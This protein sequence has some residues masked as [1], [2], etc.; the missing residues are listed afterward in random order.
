MRKQKG[1]TALDLARIAR[2]RDTIT[3]LKDA[4]EVNRLALRAAIMHGEQ[5]KAKALLMKGL[6]CSVFITL[7]VSS[8][9]RSQDR[10]TL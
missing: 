4:D 1:K 10:R 9:A 3:L 8:N 2:K 7:L 5:D 6:N